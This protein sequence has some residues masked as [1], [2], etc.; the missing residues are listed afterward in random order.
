MNLRLDGTTTD[1]RGQTSGGYHRSRVRETDSLF[2]LSRS[3]GWGYRNH[4]RI[5]ILGDLNAVVGVLFS[6]RRRAA[7][8]ALS[9]TPN[10]QGPLMDFHIL[11][12]AGVG[13]YH[14]D[15]HGVS[16]NASVVFV[17]SRYWLVRASVSFRD[18]ILQF[19]GRIVFPADF[20][21]EVGDNQFV[22]HLVGGQ[23]A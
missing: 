9:L 20:C 18:Q 23:S 17:A 4:R 14:L 2:W 3:S 13:L 7:H 10:S 21:D 12:T 19:G 11:V 16:F 8:T 1:C 6:D 5:P 15:D 22:E